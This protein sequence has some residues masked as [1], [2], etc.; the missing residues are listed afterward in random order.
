MAAPTC[1]PPA[2]SFCIRCSS[3]LLTTSSHR[4]VECFIVLVV[5]FF[6]STTATR[7]RIEQLL[8]RGTTHD[9]TKRA[10]ALELATQFAE[11]LAHQVVDADDALSQWPTMSADELEAHNVLIRKSIRK[12]R[13]N[14]DVV[15]AD[16]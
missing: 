7:E 10:T 14:D 15:V 3:A 4:A 11:L 12:Q 9:P 2:P 13:R 16:D 1:L 5:L 8:A 6:N